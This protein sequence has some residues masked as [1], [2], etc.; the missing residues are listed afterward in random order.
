MVAWCGGRVGS[1][2]LVWWGGRPGVVGGWEGLV[3]WEG[4]ET[5]R[6]DVA[7]L[8]PNCLGGLVACWLAA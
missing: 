4:G 6:S 3:W 2:G 7:R 1:G 5:W 8:V